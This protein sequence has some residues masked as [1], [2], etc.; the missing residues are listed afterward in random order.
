MYPNLIVDNFFEDPDSIVDLSA[1]IEYTPSDD[2]RWPGLRSNYLHQI[3]TRLFDF[4]SKKI[5]HLFYAN[6]QDW[7]YEIS[8]QKINPFSNN[9]Y[10]KKNCGW[11]HKDE[12]NFGGVIFLTKN[13][14]DDTGVTIFKTKNGYSSITNQEQEV[15]NKHFLGGAIDDDRYNQVYEMYHQ[16][17][18]ET[19]K[20]KNIFNRLVLFNNNTFHSVQTYG[21]KQRLT[22]SFFNNYVKTKLPPLYR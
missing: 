1:N 12:Y 4:I 11:V 15:K 17:F 6:C 3:D 8:F 20:I 9:Q 14:D 22:L 7:N 5:T 19:I 10:D 16:Q 21:T 18:E 13:P 2:G